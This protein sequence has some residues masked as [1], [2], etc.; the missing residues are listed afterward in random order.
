ML[1]AT[2]LERAPKDAP[3]PRRS[4]RSVEEEDEDSS[5]K[6]KKKAKS[7]VEPSQV[8]RKRLAKN[9]GGW[10]S[11]SFAAEVDR[12]WLNRDATEVEFDARSYAPQTGDVVL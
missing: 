1:N 7:K 2:L 4:R 12:S 5:P 9:V 3:A 8:K 6:K 10:I 11:P